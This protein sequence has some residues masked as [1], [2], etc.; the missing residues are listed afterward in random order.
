MMRIFSALVLMLLTF[1]AAAKPMRIIS[2][3]PCLDAI[4]L[5]VAMPS[6]IAAL[7]PYARKPQSTALP[8]NV[9]R[10]Y[11]TTR[12]TVDDIILR[13]SDLVL[14]SIYETPQLRSALKKYAIP[15]ELY[16]IANSVDENFAQ[17]RA[18]SALTGNPHLGE[19]LIAEIQRAL[20]A[21]ASPASAR[22]TN[23]LVYRSEG[24][25][26]GT[27]TL[28]AELLDRTGFANASEAYGIKAFGVL[29]L[30]KLVR[31]PPELLLRAGYVN[32]RSRILYHPIVAR[33]KIPARDFPARSLNCGGPS[34]ID[35]VQA[36]AKI[37]R[38][39]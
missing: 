10:Q 34:I 29:P 35:A 5:K 27:G 28:T 38:S 36:L 37:R 17:I 9:A 2:L 25:V 15:F 19:T 31:A 18:I 16:D 8:V 23:T 6:Q 11:A 21:S 1:S 39:L 20:T 4:L 32:G 3:N 24:L 26:L 12:G 14:G 33:A 30:E 13:G 22:K 7:S